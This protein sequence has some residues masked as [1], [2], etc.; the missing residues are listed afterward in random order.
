MTQPLKA[1]QPN[2]LD[3]DAWDDLV[4]DIQ[5]NA[6]F[7]DL[8]KYNCVFY[9]PMT[10]GIADLWLGDHAAALKSA[11]TARDHYPNG[12]LDERRS[13]SMTKVYEALALVRLGRASEARP[14][15]EPEYKLRSE[16]LGLIDRVSPE[17][18]KLRTTVKWRELIQHG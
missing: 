1:I 8:M 17:V 9:A 6:P 12:A 14:L 5:P 2:T 7:E 15:I 13:L 3:E 16:A 18:R 10:E 11:V 4:Q